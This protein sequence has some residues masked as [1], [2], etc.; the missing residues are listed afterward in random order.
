[1]TERFYKLKAAEAIAYKRLQDYNDSLRAKH[2][3][4][5]EGFVMIHKKDLSPEEYRTHLALYN[6]WKAIGEAFLKEELLEI[7]RVYTGY[8]E[9]ERIEKEQAEKRW[10]AFLAAL[11]D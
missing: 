7:E 10:A 11:N 2:Y 3:P 1:M 6:S 5:T 9:E 8:R 4:E